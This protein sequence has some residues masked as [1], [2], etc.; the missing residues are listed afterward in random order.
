MVHVNLFLMNTKILPHLTLC[1]V[2]YFRDPPLWSK[3]LSNGGAD[4]DDLVLIDFD[5]SMS[6]SEQQGNCT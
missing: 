3:E 5:K 6:M 1:P 2:F 4:R